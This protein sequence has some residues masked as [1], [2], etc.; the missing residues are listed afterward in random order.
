MST[1]RPF[2]VGTVFSLGTVAVIAN[3]DPGRAPVRLWR[4]SPW[5]GM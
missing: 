2:A 5:A 3:Q 4:V 1:L